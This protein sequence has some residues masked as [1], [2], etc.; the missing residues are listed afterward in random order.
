MQLQLNACACLTIQFSGQWHATT[1]VQ[2]HMLC[3]RYKQQSQFQLENSAAHATTNVQF[4]LAANV[5]FQL[6]NVQI[7]TSNVSLLFV[8]HVQRS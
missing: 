3:P 2:Q 6:P 4:Q 8:F 5:Q 1:N 7:Q